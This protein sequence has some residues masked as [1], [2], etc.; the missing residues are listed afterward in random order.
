M[1]SSHLYF[2]LNTF[3]KSKYRILF[4]KMKVDLINQQDNEDYDLFINSLVNLH[5]AYKYKVEKQNV[6]NL[7]WSFTL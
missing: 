7:K 3:M 4:I 2:H 1:H 6:C 5:N